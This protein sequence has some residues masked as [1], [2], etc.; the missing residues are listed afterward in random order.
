MKIH[1]CHPLY[2][3]VFHYHVPS[4]NT[5]IDGCRRHSLHSDGADGAAPDG[6]VTLIT[7]CRDGHMNGAGL[8]CA[9]AMDGHKPLCSGQDVG[10]ALHRALLCSKSCDGFGFVLPQRTDLTWSKLNASLAANAS[11]CL[12]E[13]QGFVMNYTGPSDP[14]GM[15]FAPR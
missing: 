5:S 12:F 13:P 2:I 6:V 11:V 7:R 8:H 9:A 14:A 15:R 10:A 4:T 3:P 1:T